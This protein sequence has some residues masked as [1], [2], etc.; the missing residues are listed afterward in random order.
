MRL[1]FNPMKTG[2]LLVWL[3]IGLG[4]NACEGLERS[5]V[6]VANVP[7]SDL[8]FVTAFIAPQDTVLRVRV[9]RTVPVIGSLPANAFAG[10]PIPNA[11]V[12]ISSGPQSVTLGY[13][14]RRLEYQ[15]IPRSF[16]VRAGETY[17]LRIQLTNGSAITSSC[18]IPAEA[19]PIQ[20][21]RILREPTTTK[22]RF[23]W[24]DLPGP[25]NFYAVSFYLFRVFSDGTVDT[26]GDR[27]EEIFSDVSDMEGG[28]F[29]TKLIDPVWFSNERNALIISHT[30]KLYYDYHR[31][32]AALLLANDNPFAD[33][34]RLPTNMR[35]AHG[36]FCG[37]TRAVGSIRQ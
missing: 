31:A 33:P 18:T 12:S 24:P 29:V 22:V 34:I 19:V 23:T 3:A 13:N 2:Q 27:L 4:L 7:T 5:V 15:T 25:N 6:E 26:T 9:E 14:G 30:D 28:R 35:G 16:T 8:P 21:I 20:S 37:Y 11:T 17:Q 36:V 1:N 10:Q 32:L